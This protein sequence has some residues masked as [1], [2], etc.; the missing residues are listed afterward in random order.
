MADEVVTITLAALAVLGTLGGAALSPTLAARATRRSELT[1]LYAE[2]LAWLY[3]VRDEQLMQSA[4][5]SPEPLLAS[6]QEPGGLNKI[7]ARL[8]LMAPESVRIKAREAMQA[9]AAFWN[10]HLGRIRQYET[11]KPV[12]QL[13]FR[14]QLATLVE[15][16]TQAIQ[17]LED[18]M[19]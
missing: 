19:R 13:A 6:G 15:R 3:V 1:S 10:Y 8:N 12:E 4:V 11:A 7:D 2:F 16:V 18:A 5:P 17:E 9:T 14:L